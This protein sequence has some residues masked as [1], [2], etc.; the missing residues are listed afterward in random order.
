M[1]NGS[2]D[3][4]LDSAKERRAEAFELI[5]MI[6]WRI[7]NE[8]NSKAHGNEFLEQNKVRESARVMLQNSVL[9]N[10]DQRQPTIPHDA[11]LLVWCAP[12]ER[13]IKINGDAALSSQNGIAGLAFVMRCHRGIVLVAGSRHISFA[14]S[15]V[16]VEAKAILWV[17]QVA[18]S[19]GCTR[20]VLETDSHILV[21]AFRHVKVLMHIRGLFMQILWLCSL[22]TSCTWSFV[23]RERN[24]VAYELARNA[25][26]D[27]VDE[28]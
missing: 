6:M 24:K 17:I 14:D 16:D 23:R 5:L 4:M 9:K 10:R 11:S 28:V 26:G 13:V 8:R 20:V 12:N 2:V 3:E 15:V 7:W 27:R 1:V 19:R 18:L 21:D 22:F 25:F